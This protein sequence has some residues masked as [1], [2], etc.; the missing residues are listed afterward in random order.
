MDQENIQTLASKASLIS[1]SDYSNNKINNKIKSSKKPET[2][3]KY[4]EDTP[5]QR[6]FGI[7]MSN[8]DMKK[9]QQNRA[10]SFK[11]MICSDVVSRK[12][13][14]FDRNQINGT[15]SI[16]SLSDETD[17]DF[18]DRL[19]KNR[20]ASTERNT[21]FKNGLSGIINK[22]KKKDLFNK[23]TATTLSNFKFDMKKKKIYDDDKDAENVDDDLTM[24]NVVDGQKIIQNPSGTVDQVNL[25]KNI[26]IPSSNDILSSENIHP[27]SQSFG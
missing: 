2:V 16:A 21:L 6:K 7:D 9:L 23:Q 17:D 13:I 4:F 14:K 15:T 25:F 11:R 22:K 19:W 27:L 18:F 20:S 1:S 5:G 12:K 26:L 10:E 24:N 8:F 3:S